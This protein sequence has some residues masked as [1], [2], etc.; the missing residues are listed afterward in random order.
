MFYGTIR[1]HYQHVPSTS[2]PLFKAVYPMTQ[3]FTDRLN[4]LWQY[5]LPHHV[6]S[7]AIYKATRIQAKPV[8]NALIRA[9]IRHFDI[10]MSLAAEQ[11]INAYPH[12][13]SFFTRTLR[14]DAR[15]VCQGKNEIACP[16]DGAISQLGDISNGRI[17]QAKGHDYS[18]EALVGGYKH[19]HDEFDGGE[20]ATI[21]LSPRDYHRIHMPLSGKLREVIY[22]PGRLFSVNAATTRA[23]PGLFARNERLVAVFDTEIGPMAVILVA[24]IFV[25]GIETVWS[26]N[27]GDDMFRKF[28]HWN[29]AGDP[30]LPQVSLGKGEEMGRFN[31]GST[32]ILLF[33]K[34]KMNWDAQAK[35]NTTVQMGQKLGLFAEQ[36]LKRP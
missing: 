10:D 12:F 30:H 24:A 19:L 5:P 3:K 20:F 14:A 2:Q 33:G 11:D 7:R 9:A 16:V 21:Y 1:G 31:M 13:N 8:K 32:V 4:A 27:F 15:P 26:G 25:A 18:L 23:I 29:H 28:Q 17:F 35:A 6:L 36:S 22:I 34:N